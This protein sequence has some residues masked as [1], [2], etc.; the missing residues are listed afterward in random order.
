ML[1]TNRS[2]KR[3]PKASTK[4][5]TTVSGRRPASAPSAS[6][7]KVIGFGSPVSTASRVHGMREKQYDP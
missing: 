4:T 6:G 1:S 7:G 5:T 3:Q 2:K